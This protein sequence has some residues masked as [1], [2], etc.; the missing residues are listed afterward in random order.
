[1]YYDGEIINIFEE[2][3]KH[4][5]F[6]GRYP[7]SVFQRYLWIIQ[8]DLFP[9]MPFIMGVQFHNLD[10]RTLSAYGLLVSNRTNNAFKSASRDEKT[11]IYLPPVINLENDDK[12][13]DLL[14]Q[15]SLIGEGFGGF[16]RDDGGQMAFRLQVF[17][18]HVQSVVRIQGN[19]K[20]EQH[21]I[22]WK[23]IVSTYRRY[24]EIYHQHK[25]YLDEFDEST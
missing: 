10:K 17:S 23:E 20:L 18:P 19:S 8:L 12:I 21:R 4:R 2:V 16:T 11:D 1:M 22:L 13:G 9:N 24:L 3:F 7:Q 15:I 25:I 6:G 14:T 5:L